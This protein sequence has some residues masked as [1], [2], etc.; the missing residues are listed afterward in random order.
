MAL[1]PIQLLS[2][3]AVAR[4][5]SVSLAARELGRSQPAV[6][7]QLKNLTAAVGEPLYRR[8]RQGV[9]LTA[10]GEAL[11]PHA[12]ALEHSLTGAARAVSELHGLERG[13]LSIS[14]SMTVAV[15]LLPAVL[16]RF[17]T[18]NPGVDLRLLTRNSEEVLD[19]LARGETEVGFVETELAETPPGLESHVYYRD[20][21]VLAV[22]ADHP[23]AGS[24]ELPASRLEGMKVV[25]RESGSG[26]RH[27]AEQALQALGVTLG[28][29][30]EASGIE[31]EKEAIVQGIGP[32]F[33]SALAIR[34]ELRA[35][36]LQ[37]VRIRDLHLSR[38][39]VLLHPGRERC[40]A[41]VRAF[42]DFLG[43]AGG[44]APGHG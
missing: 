35:G 30:L 1:D 15:Y 9:T 33:I 29:A 31:A 16:A 4:H 14:A 24:G 2:F 28:T 10:A 19:L 27:T 23:L 44:V 38:K 8:H 7:L 37:T 17:R 5:G 3:A 39:M 34:R 42:L 13:Q 32:G 25:T 18:A 11:L 21:V 6:S 20:E 43:G 22:K 41:A 40:S 12:R 36:L 26:T